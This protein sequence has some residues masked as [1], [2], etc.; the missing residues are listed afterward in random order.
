MNGIKRFSDSIGNMRFVPQIVLLAAALGVAPVWSVVLIARQGFG[1]AFRDWGGLL[2]LPVLMSA[3]AVRYLLRRAVRKITGNERFFEGR[4]C[5]LEIN[6]VL[7]AVGVLTAAAAAVAVGLTVN[8]FWF[9]IVGF[10]GCRFF[11][12][13]LVLPDGE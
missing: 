7:G 11:F 8:L 3:L 12:E 5:I 2:A 13:R 4:L 10:Y 1:A 9:Y 6:P